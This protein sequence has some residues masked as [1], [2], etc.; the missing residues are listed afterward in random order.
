MKKLIF[1]AACICAF[2]YIFILKHQSSST[3]ENVGTTETVETEVNETLLEKEDTNVNGNHL[4]FKGVPIDGTLKNFVRRMEKA[5][6]YHDGD[7]GGAAILTGD[8]AGH[9]GCTVT[10]STLDQKDLVSNITV[11][12]P[13]RETWGDLSGDYF[14]LKKLLTKKYGKPSASQEKFQNDFLDDDGSRM[15]HV[16]FDECKYKS[17]F[18][19]P[20]GTIILSI[21]H[22]GS[23]ACYVELRYFDKI[24]SGIITNEALKDL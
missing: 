20:K 23:N 11:W 7:K 21:A 5:G 14:S 16:T 6:F 24:N 15:R 8:F 18:K 13:P 4:T 9:K 17:T 22:Q 12:F 3:E 1:I 10:V 19:T 2:M